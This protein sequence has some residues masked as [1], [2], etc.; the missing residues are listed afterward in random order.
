[1][2]LN[3][4]ID[5]S[6]DFADPNHTFFLPEN[7]TS[8]DLESG[9]GKLR[10]KRTRF[11]A[12]MLFN[13]MVELYDDIS[14]SEWPKDIYA[15]HP[16]LPF[17]LEFISRNTVR[18]RMQS[19]A[20]ARKN[21]PSL[22]LVD[23]VRGGELPKDG[24]W[25]REKVDDG[26]L[27]TSMAGSVFLREEPWAIEIRD[28]SGRVLTQ[29]HP[30]RHFQPFG[31]VRRH[32]DYSRSFSASFTLAPGEKV[33]G[34][35]E[36]FTGL[37][38]RGQRLL[39]STTDPLSTEKAGMYKP[40]PF[41]LS[42]AGY[43]M[44]V[45]TSAP[46][47]FD[48]GAAH[49]GRN[50]ISTGDDEL[51]LFIFLG[52][53]KEIIGAYTAIT[54]RASMPPLWSFGLWMSRITYK[55]EREVREVAVK[56]REH[57]IPCD[58]IHLDTGWFETDWQCDY[59]FSKSRFDNPK[60][61]IEDLASDGFHTC[62]WQLPYFVPINRYFREIIDKHLAVV[63]A[64]GNLPT[65]D[66][67]LDFSNPDTLAWYQEKL[68]GLLRLGVSAIKTDFGE[69][70]PSN[71]LY[72]SR[73]TGFY[74]H[75]L[76]PIRYQEAAAD[77]TRKITGDTII[78]ARAAWAGAQRNPVH[79]GGD[80]AKTFPAMAATLRAGLSIGISGF[81]FWSHDMGGFGG[82]HDVDVY[83]H[84]TPFGMLTSHSRAH[85]EPPKEPWLVGQEFMDEFRL[86]TELRY[87]LMP[88]IYAQ[89]K[90]C[91]ERG[92]PML[93]ALF[94][95]YP[96]D[97]GAWLVDDEYL[98]GSDILVAPFFEPKITSRQVYLPGGK[99]TDYQT[100][101]VYSSGWHHIEA[102]PIPAL[103]LVR[104]GA[105]IPHI[106]LAQS[107]KDLDWSKI[108]LA[109]F[110]SEATSA[111]GLVCLPSDQKLHTIAVEKSGDTF[112]VK[113]DPFAGKVTWK[114]ESK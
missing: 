11:G 65:E 77:I 109:V 69:A 29:S 42:S 107:T 97:P 6:A 21:P 28:V 50:T 81:S 104:D 49:S 90:D 94:I 2:I 85:G 84:W 103:I 106:A 100:G 8:F 40:V 82:R 110:A 16:E 43:G 34:G 76:Y 64:K 30:D 35:G 48:F 111:A 25:K 74:E 73:S 59:E 78:W 62:L 86:S 52:T 92:I 36:S 57:R 98:F 58:V 47:T 93:R 113:N 87:R 20:T 46:T 27:F 102:G 101:K 39:L 10:Y 56:A 19:S 55:S 95:E 70:A 105:V 53:P 37:D 91:S 24:S 45:H 79:W 80:A 17:S 67:I 83:R 66:A 13:Q 54:G 60:K 7:L 68:A 15:E 9:A 41:F 61:M 32:S 75:N 88:Y 5:I 99:W 22:M 89:A 31:F 114:V 38:K 12:G 14:A 33:F 1:M 96:E 72:A 3:H 18:L 112:A 51:D 4:P 71:G 23:E 26:Y 44:F 108:E 63:D